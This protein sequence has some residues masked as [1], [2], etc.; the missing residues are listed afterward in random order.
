[1]EFI[2]EQLK[3]ILC[4]NY[5]KNS[6]GCDGN[7]KHNKEHEEILEKIYELERLARIGKA[8]ELAKKKEF[9]MFKWVTYGGGRT[10]WYPISEE[11]YNR[12]LEWA[13]I[14]EREESNE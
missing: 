14:K 5:M 7:C 1:M 10:K 9:E 3:C 8:F 4:V 6:N 13:E 11:E 2:S 12:V